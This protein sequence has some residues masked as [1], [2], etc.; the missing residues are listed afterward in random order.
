M[1]LRESA[2]AGLLLALTLVM[3]TG[4]ASDV[5]KVQ[6]RV[7][8]WEALAKRPPD[9][10]YVVDPPDVLSIESPSDS[11]LDRTVPIRQ[12]GTVTLPYLEDVHVAGL[13]TIQVREKLENLYS[14]YY[15]EPRILVSVADFKSKHIYVYG[16]VGRQ[17]AIPYTGAMTVSDV[18]G[19]VG[20]VTNR[21]AWRRLKVIRGDPDN[22]EVTKVNFRKIMLEGDL[23]EDVSLAENDIVR[24]P[25]TVLAWVGYRIDELLFP[26]RGV[27]GAASTVGAFKT[28]D[29]TVK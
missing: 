5:M 1:R 11:S 6:P 22:P 27:L 3:L 13:T 7:T 26:F 24:V 21:A 16:E 9:A 29:D 19:S 8:S 17:G 12:D 15:Q 14:K 25:P 28:I 10:T 23:R 4:C 2:V 18:I 20:G